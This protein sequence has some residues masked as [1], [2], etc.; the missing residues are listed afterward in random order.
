MTSLGDMTRATKIIQLATVSVEDYF[1]RMVE[2]L[3]EK[4]VSEKLQA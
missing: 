4:Q 3:T 2:V 1:H